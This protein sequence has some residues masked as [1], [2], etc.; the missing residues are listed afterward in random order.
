MRPLTAI[1][2]LPP[3]RQFFWQERSCIFSFSNDPIRLKLFFGKICGCFDTFFASFIT[4]WKQK[5]STFVGK[6]NI[7]LKNIQTDQIF[8]KFKTFFYHGK[9]YLKMHYKIFSCQYFI[10]KL[11][12]SFLTLVG[13]YRKLHTFFGYMRRFLTASL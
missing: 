2:P 5:T 8:Q 6:S 13:R 7:R 11:G 3:K 1:A 10:C 9:K 4:F 12:K